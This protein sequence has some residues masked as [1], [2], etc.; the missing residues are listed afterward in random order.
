MITIH[1]AWQLGVDQ[2]VGSIEVGK[3]GDIAVFSAHPFSPD[4]RC[5]MTLVDGTV[6]FDRSRDL[7]AR[8]GPAAAPGGAR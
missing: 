2:R 4:A 7:A 1:P 3:D 5:E 6:Y 8:P